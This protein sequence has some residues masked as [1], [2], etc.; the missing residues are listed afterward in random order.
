MMM[1]MMMM[2]IFEA[3]F[4][5]SKVK[6]DLCVEKW[7]SIALLVGIVTSDQTVPAHY[8][9]GPPFPGLGLG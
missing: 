6:R 7:R 9:Q 8:A 2:M 3:R 1:M 4:T 5:D